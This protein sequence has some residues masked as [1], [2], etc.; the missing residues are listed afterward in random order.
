MQKTKSYK[1]KTM[2]K[3]DNK[4]Q[5]PTEVAKILDIP[6]E[7]YNAV[8]NN[9]KDLKDLRRVSNEKAMI[10][11]IKSEKTKHRE[12][13]KSKQETK[14]KEPLKQKLKMKQG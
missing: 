12:K 9:D 10:M 5:Y 11:A 7:K 14:N 3:T 2:L 8:K 4:E 6:K 13:Q 1:E